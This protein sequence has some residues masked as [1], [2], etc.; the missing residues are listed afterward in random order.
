MFKKKGLRGAIIPILLFIYLRE[1][2]CIWS[3]IPDSDLTTE[4]QP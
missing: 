2:N 1:E 4:F 3:V